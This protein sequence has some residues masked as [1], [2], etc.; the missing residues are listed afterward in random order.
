MFTKNLRSLF[1]HQGGGQGTGLVIHFLQHI[2]KLVADHGAA[3]KATHTFTFIYRF[4]MSRGG[5]G[6]EKFKMFGGG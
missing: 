4:E 1:H 3:R 5:D 6:M 2:E